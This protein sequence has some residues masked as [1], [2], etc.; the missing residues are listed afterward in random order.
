MERRAR[1]KKKEEI[2]KI[3]NLVNWC[4]EEDAYKSPTVMNMEFADDF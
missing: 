4:I 1:Y 2:K 3:K